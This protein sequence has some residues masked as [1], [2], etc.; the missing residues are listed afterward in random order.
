MDRSIRTQLSLIGLALAV[1]IAIG[2]IVDGED[3]DRP[4]R[5][6]LAPPVTLAG[7]TRDAMAG[8]A[9]RAVDIDSL[10]RLLE[11][12]IETR[13]ALERRV[14]ELGRQVDALEGGAGDRSSTEVAASANADD[15]VAPSREG[16]EAGWFDRQVLLDA[17]IGDALADELQAFYEQLEMERLYLRDQSVREAWNREQ[18]REALGE[19]EE[20][21]AALKDR[22]GEE[23][24]DA[25]LYASG[26]PNRVAVTSLLASAPAAQAGIEAGDHILRYDNQRVYNWFELR[27][28]TADGD[29]GDTVSVEVERDGQTLQFYLARGPLG[30]RMNT[31][32]VAP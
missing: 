25:Y 10:R 32:S 16:R 20:R 1:G 11:T 9:D 29:I 28:A 31:L 12:E 6:E 14:L 2:F 19:V 7:V 22:L 30:I 23:G 18:Y 5:A 27:E 15:Q 21:E 24:Y 3:G 13:R 26:Q 8:S 17:G 4:S